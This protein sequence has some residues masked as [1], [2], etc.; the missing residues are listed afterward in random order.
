MT[1]RDDRDAQ[2][3]RIEQL[4]EA[5][6]AAERERDDAR[7]ALVVT[8]APSTEPQASSK[9]G[10]EAGARS[11]A[12]ADIVSRRR[13]G[14]CRPTRHVVEGHG[15]RCDRARSARGQLRRLLAPRPRHRGAQAGDR[16]Q[17]EAAGAGRGACGSGWSILHGLSAHGRSGRCG[18]LVLAGS[19]SRAGVSARTGIVYALRC[20]EGRARAR[21]RERPPLTC[22]GAARE[23]PSPRAR[24]HAPCAAARDLVRDRAED[25]HEGHEVWAEEGL[26]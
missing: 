22:G 4:E 11:D 8:N 14:P 15:A 13:R 2:R 25:L 3:A 16:A 12:C 9:D 18:R 6:A 19:R 21:P 24:G 20:R 5:L 7:A 26:A 1:F 23:S 17:D 10:M